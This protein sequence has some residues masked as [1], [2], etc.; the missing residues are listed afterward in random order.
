MSY[1]SLGP[2]CVTSASR[3]L[4]AVSSD[5]RQQQQTKKKS[6]VSADYQHPCPSL[7]SPVKVVNSKM[8]R[9]NLLRSLPLA[10]ARS[11][12]ATPSTTAV[13]ILSGQAESRTSAVRVV[14]IVVASA[15]RQWSSRL[16]AHP[17]SLNFIHNT[18]VGIAGQCG[19]NVEWRWRCSRQGQ[20]RVRRFS[21]RRF[22]ELGS[23][24]FSVAHDLWIGLL[25]RRDDARCRISIRYG[26][27]WYGLSCLSSSIRCHDCGRNSD[28]QDGARLAKGLRSNARTSLGCFHGI[29]CQW[30]WILSLF[31]L[32]CSRM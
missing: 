30:R 24:G 20:C 19:A 23:K 4:A 25:R 11:T 17:F 1:N 10:A 22:G 2:A 28:Q 12:R 13:R 9:V 29:L 5:N 7:S 31:L 21:C 3:R 32:G 16:H 6:S 14:M 26:S 18:T 8:M 27:I 15:L